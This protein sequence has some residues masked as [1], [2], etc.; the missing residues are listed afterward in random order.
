VAEHNDRRGCDNIDKLGVQI[1]NI[2]Q[3][4]SCHMQ[5]DVMRTFSSVLIGYLSVSSGRWIF[6]K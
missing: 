6:S 2:D 1:G 3:V 5:I 4:V